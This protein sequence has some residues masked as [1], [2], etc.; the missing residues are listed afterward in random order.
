[1]MDKAEAKLVAS[2]MYPESQVFEWG[3]GFSTLFFPLFVSQYISIEHNPGW[4]LKV[5]KM[6]LDSDSLSNVTLL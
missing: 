4:F 2:Y 5:Y 6:L 3:S 1:M